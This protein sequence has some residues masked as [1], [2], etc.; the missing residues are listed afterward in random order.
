MLIKYFIKKL[1]KKNYP[2]ISKNYCLSNINR[3]SECSRCRDVCPVKAIKYEED[4]IVINENICSGCGICR[5]ICPSKAINLKSFGEISAFNE[6]KQKDFLV[7]G[8]VKEGN[9]GNIKFPCLHGLHKEY[10]AAFIIILRNRKVYF[11]LSECTECIYGKDCNAFQNSLEKVVL[12]LKNLNIN[13][14][15]EIL[16]DS[17]KKI[18]YPKNQFSRRDFFSLIK[19][20]STYLVADIVLNSIKTDNNDEFNERK[21]LI[22]TIK[23]L[24]CI[25]EQLLDKDNGMFTSYNL[26]SKCNGCGVCE[27]VCPWNAWEVKEDKEQVSIK[28]SISLCRSCG[29]CTS[30]CLEKAI[31][32]EPFPLHSIFKDFIIKKEISLAYCKYCWDKYVPGTKDLGIC[33]KCEKMNNIRMSLKY[34]DIIGGD[35]I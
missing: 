23:N 27:A 7:V 25:E 8:C 14:D 30:M 21:F 10:L 3:F 1:T 34:N 15:Y 6:A 13:P 11:N 9:K 2:V 4:N 16:N 31:Q 29:I 32:E 12:F 20:E 26:N 18:T 22:D 17:E 28:H 19:K 35:E 33:N 5:T 24:G